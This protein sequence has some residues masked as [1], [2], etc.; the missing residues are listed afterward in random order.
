MVTA[1]RDDADV[2]VVGAGPAGSTAAYY[3]AMAGLDV[4]VLE[5]TAFPREKVCG[6][7]FTPRSVRELVEIGA[8][9]PGADPDAD[10]AIAR[11]PAIDAFLRQDM[12]ESTAIADTWQRLR[13]LVA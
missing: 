1:Q 2:I 12:D 4:L 5:K 9:V 8:Y 7:G 3:L 6:D 13:E 11:M 10:V